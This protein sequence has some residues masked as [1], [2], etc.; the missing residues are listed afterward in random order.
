MVENS[1]YT[2]EEIKEIDSN[3]NTAIEV[4]DFI[5]K[6]PSPLGEFVFKRITEDA[7]YIASVQQF[8]KVKEQ[9]L[10]SICISFQ[11]SQSVDPVCKYLGILNHYKEV[12]SL[13]T[14]TD[15]LNQKFKEI[16]RFDQ[17]PPIEGLILSYPCFSYQI[18][19]EDYLDNTRELIRGRIMERG[20]DEAYRTLNDLTEVN[21]CFIKL[22]YQTLFEKWFCKCLPKKY[23]DIIFRWYCKGELIDTILDTIFKSGVTSV[24]RSLWEL[25][26][27]K[28][29]QYYYLSKITQQRYDYY[30]VISPEIA[31]YEF[32]YKGEKKQEDVD[33]IVS[34]PCIPKSPLDCTPIDDNCIYNLHSRLFALGKID[35]KFEYFKSAFSGST[36]TT[37][38]IK[39]LH[40]QKD[41]AAFLYVLRA[42]GRTNKSYAAQAAKVFIQKNGKACSASTLDQYEQPK[43][44]YYKRLF[45]EVGITR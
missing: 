31:Y 25:L 44:S 5:V 6:L 2:V 26:V 13:V 33:I 39:W 38:P 34:L 35:C 7:Y 36:K 17:L 3:T 8:D 1:L 43:I 45:N 10:E 11:S 4:F 16:C 30:R 40:R 15:K 27:H 12:D 29:E 9:L 20:E 37:L 41:L 18:Y 32:M 22:G 19:G 23:D 24:S 21:N 14:N 28:C 42:E